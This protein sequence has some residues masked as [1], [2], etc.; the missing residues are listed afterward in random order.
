MQMVSTSRIDE[1]LHAA[2]TLIDE[3]VAQGADLVVLPEYFPIMGMRD[4]DK[5]KVREAEGRG[6]IQDFLAETAL[7][8]GVWLIGGSIPW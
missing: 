2:R 4:G 1:N 5:V 8:H 7:R 6:P 3:S